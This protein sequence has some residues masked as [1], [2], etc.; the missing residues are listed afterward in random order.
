MRLYIII[1]KVIKLYIKISKL[2][3]LYKDEQ[4]YDIKLYK[5]VN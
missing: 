4:T 2:I 3:K 1:G 5:W